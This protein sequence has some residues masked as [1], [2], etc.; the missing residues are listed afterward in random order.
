MPSDREAVEPEQ[1]AVST[2]GWQVN[3]E[4]EEVAV[5][6]R[7][8]ESLI[9]SEECTRIA[10]MYSL[11]VIEPTDLERPHIPPNGHVT[12]SER[13]LQFGVRFPLNPFFVEVLQHFSL[14]LF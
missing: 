6:C 13:Y 11:Q 12:L 10:W 14:T 4:A 2:L 1:E 3:D 8:L 9:T 5:S 7:D